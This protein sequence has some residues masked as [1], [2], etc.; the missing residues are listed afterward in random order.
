M[1]MI[2]VIGMGPGKESMMTGEAA[3]A[4]DEADI[5]VGYRYILISWVRAMMTRKNIQ[6][7]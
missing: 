1:K 3:Q 4:L 6:L 7:P 5:I 2:D